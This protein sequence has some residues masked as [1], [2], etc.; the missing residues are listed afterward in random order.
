MS[1]S[2]TEWHEPSLVEYEFE[3]G[4][5]GRK[6]VVRLGFPRFVERKGVWKWVCP[7]QFSGIKKSL[8]PLPIKDGHVHLAFGED[9]LDALTNAATAIRASL[10]RLK[11]VGREPYQFIFPKILPM[12]Y[13]L[14][15]LNKLCQL[16]DAEIAKKERA[17]SRRRLARR[18]SG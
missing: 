16:V 14:E 1:M 8:Y 6:A 2:S 18:K 4:A 10:E 13:G 17:L 7:F 9:G 11:A 12:S 5:T 3:V 15:F